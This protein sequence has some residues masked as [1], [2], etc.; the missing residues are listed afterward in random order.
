MSSR[1]WPAMV[2]IQDVLGA[3]QRSGPW[4]RFSFPPR[5][6]EKSVGAARGK[7]PLCRSSRHAG[8]QRSSAR[9]RLGSSTPPERAVDQPAAV[10]VN[11]SASGPPKKAGKRHLSASSAMT[12][13]RNAASNRDSKA[14]QARLFQRQP[15]RLRLSTGQPLIRAGTCDKEYY[16]ISWCPKAARGR[17]MSARTARPYLD[18][19]V[20]PVA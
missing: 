10:E 7:S 14:G 12:A 16:H 8:T 13:N 18:S 11:E 9:S 17:G 19:R 20:S 1:G 15:A 3:A 2:L 5:L 6:F 4:I